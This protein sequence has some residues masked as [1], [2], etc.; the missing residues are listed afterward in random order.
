[1]I[2]FENV[3]VTAY[4]T[5]LQTKVIALPRNLSEKHRERADYRE[6]T[7]YLVFSS[8]L[9]LTVVLG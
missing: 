7:A 8:A 9:H 4:K 3:V 2:F 5:R 1:M 6:N